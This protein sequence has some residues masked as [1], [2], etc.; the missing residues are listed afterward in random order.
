MPKANLPL[1]TLG[2]FILWMG[3]FG[4]NGGSQL[5]LDSV[6]DLVAI[7]SFYIN[8]NL[9]AASGVVAAIVLT[10]ILYKKLNLTM[11]PNGALGG[12]LLRRNHWPHSGRRRGS[13]ARQVQD[14]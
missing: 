8:T 6:A 4:F 13:A 9:A 10:Q 3:W 14:R 11:A 1:A 7:S 12:L 5:A 2:T